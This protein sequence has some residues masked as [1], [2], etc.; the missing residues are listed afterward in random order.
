MAVDVLTYP[1]LISAEAQLLNYDSNRDIGIF[2]YG[3]D[4]SVRIGDGLEIDGLRDYC[5]GDEARHID[6]IASA[7]QPDGGL[8]VRQHFAEKSPLTVVISDIPTHDKYS[9]TPGSPLS[10]RGLGFVV[11][12]SVLKAGV[13]SGAPIMG[14]WTD[15]YEFGV[16]PKVF[17][18]P[19]A[20]RKATSQGLA[21]AGRSTKL[22]QQ[23][24]AHQKRS[25]I[26]RR[27]AEQPE[28]PKTET[29][30]EVIER[31]KRQTRLIA[32]TARFIVISDFRVD[33][34]E[35]SQVLK[36]LSK[37]SDVVAVQITNPHLRELPKGISV[38]QNGS[39]GVI[40]ESDQQRLMY[41]RKAA[42]KQ[43]RINEFLKNV[44]TKAYIVDTM[45]PR[46]AI[47]A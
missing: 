28:L 29:F 26:L 36:S 24:E 16:K 41:A 22:A 20:P 25:G 32:D 43:A 15:G 23:Q 14:V 42:E 18:G 34:D 10:S 46:I 9:E 12:H 6:W 31:T 27:K 21:I 45:K 8:I 19:K 44:A 35:T 7:K 1:E 40:I 13:K 38:F 30:A 2:N 37:T 5:P 17:E 47:L 4:R 11:A 33:I 3:D 39:K